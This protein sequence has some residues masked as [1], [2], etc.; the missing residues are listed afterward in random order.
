MPELF[1]FDLIQKRSAKNGNS[2]TLSFTNVVTRC[3]DTCT[4]PRIYICIFFI[5]LV[6]GFIHTITLVAPHLFSSSWLRLGRRKLRLGYK[7]NRQHALIKPT[8]C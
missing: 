2:H 1:H 6:S 8:A 7:F 3:I 4:L 5:F